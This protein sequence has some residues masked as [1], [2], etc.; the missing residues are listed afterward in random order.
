LEEIPSEEGA[1]EV[2]RELV[3]L[4]P[5]EP[6]FLAHLGRFLS[7]RRQEHQE[8]RACLERAVALSEKDY[9]LHHMM[10][11]A[12]RQQIYGLLEADRP[13]SEWLP[14]A[15]EAS[16]CF[17]RARELNLEDEHGYISEAQMLIRMLDKLKRSRTGNLYNVFLSGETEPLLRESFQHVEDLLDQV[18]RNRE[19]EGASPFEEQCRAQLHALYGRF[20]QALS[21]WNSLLLRP[22]VYAPPMR[23]QVVWTYLSRSGHSWD[24]LS[25]GEISSIVELLEQNLREEPNDERNLRLWLRAVRRLSHPPTVESALEKIAYWSANTGSAEAAYYLYV[26]NSLLVLDG[27]AVALDA[28]LA[29]LERCRGLVRFRRNR[30]RSYEWLGRGQGLTA[31]VHHSRLG[32]W[33]RDKDFWQNDTPLV[34]VGGRISRISGPEAGEVEAPGGLKAFFVP[35]RV[36]LTEERYINRAVDFYL[37][38]SYDGLRAWDV[39]EPRDEQ[40]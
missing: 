30:T 26:L 20:D 29:S 14:L 35:G 7:T 25:G 13:V 1:L 11:M 31:L 24:N 10:G 12:V 33:Q 16:G 9:I 19:G 18:R 32:D 15:K 4:Y 17:T 5:D 2:L 28:A 6:H 36:G 23:R 38:F 8:A 22:S 27:S 3:D 40:A 34:R 37:G 21:T 39:K